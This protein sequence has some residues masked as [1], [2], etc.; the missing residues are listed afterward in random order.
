MS[1]SPVSADAGGRQARGQRLQQLGDALA[2]LG[3]AQHGVAGIDA[4]HILDLGPDA[5]R[6]G[7]GQ[8][9]LVERDD[10]LVVVIDRLVHIGER[11][12]L[13]ALGRIDHQQRAFAG[14][15]RA[16]HLIGEIDMAG[17]VDNVQGKG[18]AV[19]RLVVQPHRLRLDGDPAL[20]L[21]VH[22]VE[23]LVAHLALGQPAAGLDQPVRQGRFAV[24]D[25]GDD[26]EIADLCGVGH[27]GAV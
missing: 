12:R 5:L 24:V 15:E 21:K 11:L 10:D 1:P 25:M 17:R 27:G 26:R 18:P 9:D 13:D 19:G 20:A 6:L 14:S 22:I 16:A 2:G 8:I 23:H 3:R 7:G 4:D